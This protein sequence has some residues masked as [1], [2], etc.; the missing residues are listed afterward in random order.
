MHILLNNI[1]FEHILC[2]IYI[3]IHLVTAFV[4]ESYV[5][6]M[7]HMGYSDYTNKHTPIVD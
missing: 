6:N 2:K 7:V 5:C 1:F 3:S 4:Y